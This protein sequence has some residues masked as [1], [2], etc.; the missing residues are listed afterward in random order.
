MSKTTQISQSGQNKHNVT[1]RLTH[2]KLKV[3]KKIYAQYTHVLCQI[4]GN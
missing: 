2:H 4:K 1:I 3:C